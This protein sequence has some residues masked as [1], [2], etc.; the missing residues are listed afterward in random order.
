VSR[1]HLGTPWRLGRGRY[2]RVLDEP[3]DQRLGRTGFHTWHR[4]V[5]KLDSSNAAFKATG[6]F[7][8]LACPVSGMTT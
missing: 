8:L 5:E 4:R 1:R 2:N 6:L 7:R 3:V